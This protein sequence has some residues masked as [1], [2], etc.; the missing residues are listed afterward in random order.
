MSDI[1]KNALEYYDKEK[2]KNIELLDK[3]FNIKLIFDK[4]TPYIKIFDHNN[5]YIYKCKFNKISSYFVKHKILLWE[6]GSL[7]SLKSSYEFS[8]KILNYGLDLDLNLD[9]KEKENIIL[10]NEIINTRIYIDNIIQFDIHLALIS[11]ILKSSFII[12][13]IQ[14]SEYTFTQNNKYIYTKANYKNEIN[15]NKDKIL[16]FLFLY[17]FEKI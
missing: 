2:E 11:Y 3:I 13:F 17:D 16:H 14:N 8:R 15:K 4:K 10:K 7:A 9:T 1:I 6:W 5:N 12:P